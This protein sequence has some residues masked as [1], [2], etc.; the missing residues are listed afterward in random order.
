MEIYNFLY[1]TTIDELPMQGIYQTV[2]E[3]IG[4]LIHKMLKGCLLDLEN[5]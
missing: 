3:Q 4:E 5:G 2:D 1:T